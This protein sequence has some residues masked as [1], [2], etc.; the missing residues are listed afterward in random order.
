MI[1]EWMNQLKSDLNTEIYGQDGFAFVTDGIF[2]AAVPY[3]GNGLAKFGK[4][5]SVFLKAEPTSDRKYS[6]G[7]LQKFVDR[8][9]LKCGGT[10][11]SKC[12]NCCGSKQYSCVCP[13]CEDRHDADCTQCDAEGL[14]KCPCKRGSRYEVVA[15]G[16]VFD[17]HLIHRAIAH[18]PPEST[19]RVAKPEQ[20]GPASLIGNDWRIVIMPLSSQLT[21]QHERFEKMKE[22]AL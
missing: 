2:I 11:V 12:E 9:C 15:F 4:R 17:A 8:P 3:T 13:E 20:K 7:A 1:P 16:D 19:F 10:G 18:L 6:I 22:A 14:A 5:A 21:Q